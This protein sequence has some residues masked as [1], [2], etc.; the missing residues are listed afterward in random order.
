M[1]EVLM[2]E[3]DE[4]IALLLTK[5]VKNYAINITNYPNPLRALEALKIDKYDL[6]ILDLSLPEMDGLD[7][8]KIIAS[9]Y[10]LPIIIS[11]ARSDVSD[12]VMGLELGAQDYMPKPYDPRELVARIKVVLNR[13]VFP[14]SS[15]TFMLDTVRMSI[16]HN[17][18]E[19]E[20]T[21]GEY[22]VFK[23]LIEAK[24]MVVTREYIANNSDSIRWDS[25]DRSIDV[26]ISR[27][28]SKIGDNPKSPKYIKSIRGVGYKFIGD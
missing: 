1:T 15:Q 10:H 26:I 8:C 23:L 13:G 3:D 6:V 16:K 28:R 5:Y 14:K 18:N 27:I 22:E 24:D 9:E 4:D 12:K 7:V 17:N 11:S 20:L 19:L 25:S 21:T 2:I